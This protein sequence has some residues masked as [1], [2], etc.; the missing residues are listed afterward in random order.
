LKKAEPLRAT[1]IRRI[2]VVVDLEDPLAPAL[3]I[4]EF[5]KL[6]NREPEPP[7]YRIAS[8]EVLTCPEDNHVVLVTECAKCPR[9]IKRV[10]DVI[11][12]A[13]KRVR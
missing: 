3:T 13:A 11:Y 7:R 8:I 9:F 6:F 10:E 12:C 2:S 5:E 4:D 1:P